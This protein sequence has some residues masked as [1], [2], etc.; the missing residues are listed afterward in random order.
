M[1]CTERKETTF[2]LLF[3]SA[4][5]GSHAAP[6]APYNRNASAIGFASHLEWIARGVTGV[7]C[8]RSQEIS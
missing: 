6:V 2:S 1:I 3:K 4:F 8:L 7:A 5:I